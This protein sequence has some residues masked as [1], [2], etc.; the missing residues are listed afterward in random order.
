MSSGETGALNNDYKKIL[1][2]LEKSK[3][4]KAGKEIAAATGIEAKAVSC[5]MTALKKKGM[6]DSPERCK[7]A[8]TVAGRDALKS[9]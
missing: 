9:D 8:I 2:A 7:Y 4:P 5:K 3:E 6:V 1:S